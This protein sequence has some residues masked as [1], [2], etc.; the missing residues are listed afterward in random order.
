MQKM[1]F[2]QIELGIKNLAEKAR[3]GK[4]KIEEMVGGTFTITNGGVFGSML[5]YSNYQ[6]PSICYFRYA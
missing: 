1:D 5:S 3:D 4:I 6:S 2:H